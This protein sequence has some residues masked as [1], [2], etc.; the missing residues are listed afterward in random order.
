MRL[1]SEKHSLEAS[2][3]L[4]YVLFKES[5]KEKSID[6]VENE[7]N[8]FTFDDDDDDG[9]MTDI[10]NQTEKTE[11]IHHNHHCEMIE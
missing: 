9:L 3:L 11:S 1:H 6:L 4:V 5:K 2:I 10:L 7:R 8:S